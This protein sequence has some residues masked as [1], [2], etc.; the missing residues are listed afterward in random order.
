MS[1]KLVE[2][3]ATAQLRKDI[4]DSLQT[5]GEQAII[6][7]MRHPGIDDGNERCIRCYDD[8][9]SSAEQDCT[10]CYGTGFNDP[11]KRAAKVW[12]MFSDQVT[13][14]S[15]DKTG[16]WHPD[17]RTMHTEAFP[18]LMEHDYVVRVRRW[19]S[20]GR[21][22][23]IE[24]FYSVGKVKPN[25]V[26][27]GNRFGQYSWD[28]VGQKATVSELPNVMAITKYPILSKSFDPSVVEPVGSLA[29]PA[30]VPPDTKVVYVPI[31]PK[32]N[33]DAP[34]TQSPPGIMWRQVFWHHQRSM[35]STWTIKHPFGYDPSV[36]VFIND[37]EWDT[38]TEYPDDHTAVLTFSAP[39]S[40]VAQLI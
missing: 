12:A 38:D 35:A 28:V 25:S 27:T 16:V 2:D 34:L 18:L 17:V 20:D 7:A 14:E 32:T 29:T 9:Y 37:E 10:I 5:A 26:R 8:V 4:R 22:A 33:N 1:V 11:V 24:A 3:F 21:A 19:T 15:Y 31:L 36:T 13:D 23:E 39:Q 40:G 30:P 6:L